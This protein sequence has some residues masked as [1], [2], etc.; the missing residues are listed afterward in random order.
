MTE[1]SWLESDEKLGCI[2]GFF[3]NYQS[4]ERLC[5]FRAVCNTLKAMLI[6]ETSDHWVQRR[7][8][9]RL[10]VLDLA[11]GRGG[12]LWKWT[13]NRPCFL[14]VDASSKCIEAARTRFATL[15][16]RGR[17]NMEAS[18]QVCD[19]NRERFPAQDGSVDVASSQFALQFVFESDACVRHYFSEVLR[20]LKPRGYFL[21]VFPNGDQVRAAL[22]ERSHAFFGHFCLR[23]FAQTENLFATADPPVGIPYTFSLEHQTSCAEFAVSPAYLETLLRERGFRPVLSSMV[24]PAT[25]FL[26]HIGTLEHRVKDARKVMKSF[27]CSHRDWESLD[28]FSVCLVTLEE[29]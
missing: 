20:V 22:R 28:L 8:G 15:M 19:V 7:S 27:G 23:A 2:V 4:P 1:N 9:P 24:L 14:G 11:C 5:T 12:D 10:H 13:K 21:A 16:S 6:E 3:D 17:S 26:D 25:A 18:F 29:D